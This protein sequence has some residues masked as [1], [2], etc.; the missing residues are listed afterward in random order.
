MQ[1]HG[2]PRSFQTAGGEE[3]GLTGVKTRNVT[4]SEQP[5][6]VEQRGDVEVR[7]REGHRGDPDGLCTDGRT[8]GHGRTG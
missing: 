3:G 6:E 4:F 7:L 2:G 1:S 8:D 5:V